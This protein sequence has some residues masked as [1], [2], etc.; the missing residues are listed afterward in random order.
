M[1]LRSDESPH[2]VA[3][4]AVGLLTPEVRGAASLDREL[5]YFRYEKISVW[6]GGGHSSSSRSPRQ[7][8]DR[9]PFLDTVRDI[10]AATKKG[11]ESRAVRT[12]LSARPGEETL[13]GPLALLLAQHGDASGLDRLVE[14]GSSGDTSDLPDV[15]IAGFTLSR[16]V[17]YLDVLRK[18]A[19]KAEQEYKVRELLKAVRGMRG[20]EA[21]EFRRE[22]NKRLRELR[23]R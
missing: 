13:I 2:V 11:S 17:K 20:P 9:P 8:E 19:G 16:D 4:A 3:V 18:A 22:I 21:R 10:L 14:R 7:L 6:R 12:T 23:R 5:R 1:P 15:I